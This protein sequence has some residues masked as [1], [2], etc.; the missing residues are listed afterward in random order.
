MTQPQAEL[1][2]LYRAGLKTAADMM[3]VSL[4]NAERLQNQQLV[5]IRTALDQQVKSADELA[6]AKSLDELMAFQTRL[7][8]DQFERAMS[9]WGGL[10]QIATENQRK[11]IGQFQ[12]QA[13]W[14]SEA[15]AGSGAQ[16]PSS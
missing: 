10:V 9:Y 16:A 1:F 2:D 11:A 5:A 14:L 6:R 12:Q 8:G 7:A 4:E 15:T 13:R 3:K